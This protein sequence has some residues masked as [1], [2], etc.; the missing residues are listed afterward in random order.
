MSMSPTQLSNAR[1][2]LSDPGTSAVQSIQITNATGG[3]WTATFNGQTTTALPYNVTG[4]VLQNALTALSTIGVGQATVNTTP[5]QVPDSN[6][7]SVYLVGTLGNVAQP[8]LTI[9]TSGLTGIGI[10]G[11]V[12]QVQAGGLTAFTDNEL[13]DLYTDSQLNFELAIAKAFDVL[14]AGGA[15]FTF[16]VAGQT[17]EHKDQISD[18]L[19]ER[20]LWWH[21]WANASR[22]FIPATIEP[23]PPRLRAVPFNAGQSATSLT[24][25]DPDWFNRRRGWR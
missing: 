10:V 16:F 5:S 19:V 18:H 20:A 11:T 9:D 6:F 1:M 12:L 24:Y 22:Q 8:M 13:G 25:A 23:V 15:K 21:Q 7:Y 14:V 17:Q 2:Y 3:T 4:N